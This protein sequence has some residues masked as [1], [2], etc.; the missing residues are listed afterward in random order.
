MQRSETNTY[1]QVS[2]MRPEQTQYLILPVS[3][4]L[5]TTKK[6]FAK[7]YDMIHIKLCLPGPERQLGEYADST[8]A[9]LPEKK[10]HHGLWTSV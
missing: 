4:D 1:V 3:R 5:H 9:Q 6:H 2:G 7:Y 10:H 8:Q